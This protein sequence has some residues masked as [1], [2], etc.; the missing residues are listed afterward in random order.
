MS[1]ESRDSKMTHLALALAEGT[2]VSAW[3]RA[4]QVP[5][6]TAFHWA[7]DPKV[8][9]LSQSVRRRAADHAAIQLSRRARWAAAEVAKL[10]RDARSESVR[11]EA[12][13]FII[14]ES[15][16]AQAK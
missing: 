4:N 10:A 13:L 3:A 8:R 2:S 7:S 16:R 14:S 15:M 11:L 1:G 12:L 9:G 6:R 5:V